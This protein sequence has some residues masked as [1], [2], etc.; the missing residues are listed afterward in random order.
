MSN[1]PAEHA[2][3]REL[4]EACRSSLPRRCPEYSATPTVLRI[5]LA[6][7]RRFAQDGAHVLLSSRKQENVDKAVK[8]LKDEGLSVAGIV[9]HV[10]VGEHREK[11]I[12]KALELHGKIDI[13]VCN[14]AVNPFVGPL[15]DTTEEMWEKVFHVNV[16]STFLMVKLAVPHMQK[17]GGGSVV[18]CSSFIGYIPLPVSKN[19]PVKLINL[20]NGSKF[21]YSQCSLKSTIV[22]KK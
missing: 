17:Q 21:K 8:Q 9:C 5:G 6:I 18:I 7:A 15:L 1:P 13:L 11:L 16:I 12:T 14:A 20:F 19:I 2:C 10:G 22:K 4:R 3:V